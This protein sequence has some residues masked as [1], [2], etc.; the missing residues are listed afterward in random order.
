MCVYVFCYCLGFWW[1]FF[2]GVGGVGA[3]GGIYVYRRVELYV[4]H[5]AHVL[6][7][8]GFLSPTWVG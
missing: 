5:V 4:L 7:A 1:V 8:A 6:G 3:E 2:G